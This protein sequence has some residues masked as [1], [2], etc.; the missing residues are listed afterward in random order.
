MS[1]EATLDD[2]AAQEGSDSDSGE[3]PRFGSLPDDWRVSEIAKIAEVVGGST[4]STSNENYWGGGILWAT[5]TDI[6]A[7]SG[8]TISETEDT[9][10]DEGLGSASTHLLPPNSVLMTSRAT[11]G[12]CAVNTV[13]M[14]TNQGFKNLVPSDEIEAWYLYYRMLDTAA[15]LNSLG[16]GS[17]F[18]EV[19]KTEVQSVD[20]PVPPLP[21]QRKI[22]TVLYTVDRAIQKTEKIVNSIKKIKQEI[23]HDLFTEGRYEHSEY[24]KTH[25]GPVSAKLPKAWDVCDI[26]DISK[27]VESGETPTGG[28]K[29]YVDSGIPFVRSQNVLMNRLDLSDTAYITEEI[30][31]SMS[32]SEI[33]GGDVL[34][35]ITGASIGRV[36]PVPQEFNRGNVNQHVCRI[37]ISED[38]QLNPSFLSYFLSSPL[39]QKQIKSFQAGSTRQGL[40]YDQV[41]SIRLPVPKRGEQEKIAEFLSEIDNRIEQERNCATQLERLKQGVMQD[42]LSGTVRATN[43]N[44]EVPDEIAKY[45]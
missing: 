22:A 25:F 15:F 1:E 21:E 18:D 20:I 14:A 3:H 35:N 28:S 9:I 36:T 32:R 38:I 34:I 41:R 2:F 13:E 42:L 4:P 24:N 26:E 27:T 10:S 5:P 11:I 40:N 19:S 37:R 39:G 29:V 44:I 31:K 23:K 6:T 8:N 30:H 43:T 33:T 16:S 45:G 12:K 7:L 17:T